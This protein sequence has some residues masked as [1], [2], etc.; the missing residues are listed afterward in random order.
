MERRVPSAAKAV[1]VTLAAIDETEAV[2]KKR[3]LGPESAGNTLYPL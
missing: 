1:K 2:S 3:K